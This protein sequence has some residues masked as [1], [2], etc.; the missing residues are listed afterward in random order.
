MFV[1]DATNGHRCSAYNARLALAP[2]AVTASITNDC[3]VCVMITYCVTAPRRCRSG[4]TEC[5]IAA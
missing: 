4:S 5:C 2:D 1:F 3:L